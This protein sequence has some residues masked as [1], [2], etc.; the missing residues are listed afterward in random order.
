MCTVSYE[1]EREELLGKIISC[2]SISTKKFP[3]CG[4]HELDINQIY[5]YAVASF[6]IFIFICRNLWA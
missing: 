1:S 6:N 3:G 5:I 4:R 2:T